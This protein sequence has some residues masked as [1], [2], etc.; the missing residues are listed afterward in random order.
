MCDSRP[1]SGGEI[2]NIHINAGS[3]YVSGFMFT[4]SAVR[5]RVTFK[6]SPMEANVRLDNITPAPYINPEWEA[7]YLAEMRAARSSGGMRIR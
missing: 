2:L 6:D 4:P 5:V 1:V 3:A 7:A